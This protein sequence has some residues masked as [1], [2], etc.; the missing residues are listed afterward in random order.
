MNRTHLIQ[1]NLKAV[2][3]ILVI[4]IG[5]YAV[6][7]KLG[8]GFAPVTAVAQHEA[9]L[10]ELAAAEKKTKE[11][12]QITETLTPKTTKLSTGPLPSS[13]S[14]S[15]TTV[16]PANEPLHLP[17]ETVTAGSNQEVIELRLTELGVIHDSNF[18][19]LTSQRQKLTEKLS[20]AK[21]SKQSLKSNAPKFDDK[22][23]SADRDVSIE[24]HQ[25]HIEQMSAEIAAVVGDMVTM[26]A[27]LEALSRRYNESVAKVM[28]E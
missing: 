27:R 21:L 25:A 8:P 9:P 22:I 17:A 24:K 3:L 28:A 18:K 12:E 16:A 19:K 11:A 13:E 7:W 14:V 1:S 23:S 15:N 26:D 10:A 6:Y 20:K 2:L 5:G 4:A